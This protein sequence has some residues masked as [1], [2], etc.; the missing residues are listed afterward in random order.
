ML[1]DGEPVYGVHKCRKDS[2]AD[3]RRRSSQSSSGKGD[4]SIRSRAHWAPDDMDSFVSPR[5]GMQADV[6]SAR[7]M[8]KNTQDKGIVL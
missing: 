1:A 4:Y 2:V 7:G 3:S 5:N 8:P 6:Q